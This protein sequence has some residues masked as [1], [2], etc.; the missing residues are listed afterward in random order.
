MRP[1]RSMR[2]LVF[3]AVAVPLLLSTLVASGPAWAKV[4]KGKSGFC[5]TLGSTGGMWFLGSCTQPEATGNGSVSI[6]PQPFPTS[7]GRFTSVITWGH[8]STRTNA[9][10][11]TTVA[12]T[13]SKAPKNRCA[14]G[15]TEWQLI[16]TITNNTGVI[17]V[18]GRVKILACV[19]S[20]GTVSNTFKGNKV[21][22]VKF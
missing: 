19:T 5:K 10:A 14:T 16:G 20:S 4:S 3:P 21:K 11:Q 18:K 7:V 12:F 6:T 1:C 2:L 13:E 17:G 22:Q 9:N 15:S 8:L